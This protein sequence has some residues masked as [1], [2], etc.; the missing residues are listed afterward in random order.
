MADS[1]SSVTGVLLQYKDSPPTTKILDLAVAA[2]LSRPVAVRRLHYLFWVAYFPDTSLV[3]TSDEAVLPSDLEIVCSM[4][5]S[6]RIRASAE[7][8][9]YRESVIRQKRESPCCIVM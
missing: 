6:W 2:G 9:A 1:K 3:S 8:A 4:R 7:F 5:P